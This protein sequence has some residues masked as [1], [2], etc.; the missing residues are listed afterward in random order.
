MRIK[1]FPSTTTP[2]SDD[3]FVID[4]TSGTRKITLDSLKTNLSTS[5]GT[6]G[7][8]GGSGTDFI[9]AQ[10]TSGGWYYRKWNSGL[11]ECFQKVAK[12]LTYSVMWPWPDVVSNGE[13]IA[14]AQFTLP[15]GN[16]DGF[17]SHPVA[18]VSGGIEGDI[19]SWVSYVSATPTYLDCYIKSFHSKSDYESGTI[20][21]NSKDTMINMYVIGY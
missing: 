16:S 7:S 2:A 1:E 8:S 9:V 3:V 15:F 6:G 19:H 12:R 20:S 5:L 13:I 17:S 11:K 10:G 14:N 18:L 4:G 21:A